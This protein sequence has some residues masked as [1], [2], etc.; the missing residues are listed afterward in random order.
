[1]RTQ[2]RFVS[3]ITGMAIAIAAALT[4]HPAAAASV[5]DDPKVQSAQAVREVVVEQETL[6]DGSTVPIV[7]PVPAQLKPNNQLLA[8][9]PPMTITVA[10]S[11]GS[12]I[13]PYTGQT[14]ETITV[15]VTNGG[16]PVV[17]ASVV[18]S[19]LN[20]VTDSNGQATIAI[21]L[22]GPTADRVTVD[23]QAA[24]FAVLDT[25]TQ[26]LLEVSMTDRNGEPIISPRPDFYVAWGERSYGQ[27]ILWTPSPGYVWFIVPAETPARVI[28]SADLFDGEYH[29]YQLYQDITLPGF[30]TSGLQ[31]IVLDGTN[32]LDLPVTVRL[33]REE[34]IA[35]VILAPQDSY[36]YTLFNHALHVSLDSFSR[37]H[38]TPGTYQVGYQ[39][40]PTNP[41]GKEAVL[42][43]TVTF[44]EETQ[45]LHPWL[46]SEGLASLRTTFVETP[47]DAIEGTFSLVY[48][49][50]LFPISDRH[51]YLEPG[52]YELRNVSLEIDSWWY[53]YI[54]LDPSRGAL[55]LEAGKAHDLYY[56]VQPRPGSSLSQGTAGGRVSAPITLWNSAGDALL[57][58]SSFDPAAP[59]IGEAWIYDE[60]DEEIG[61]TTVDTFGF[62][63]TAPETPADQVYTYDGAYN[64]GP[65]GTSIEFGGTMLVG[66]PAYAV[67]E[68]ESV[69]QDLPTDLTV[70]V[71]GGT[72]GSIV[73]IGRTGRS[74]A[75]DQNG[76]AHFQRITL[77]EPVPI[78]VNGLAKGMVQTYRTRE[79]VVV[80]VDG[81]D[82]TKPRSPFTV[83]VNLHGATD[84]YGA[85]VDLTLD[86]SQILV[87]GATEGNLHTTP[88]K[89]VIEPAI[90][91]EGDQ[92][93]Y[94]VSLLG[95]TPGREG[96]ATLLT[97]T[98]QLVG[99]STSVDLANGLEVTLVDSNGHP[100][101]VILRSKQMAVGTK[102]TGRVTSAGR[103]VP[104]GW[105]SL[106]D[107]TTSTHVAK[108]ETD[109]Q[110]N[111]SLI[112]PYNGLFQVV[113]G[114]QAY[115][116]T[117]GAV[118]VDDTTPGTIILDLSALYG[119]WNGDGYISTTDLATLMDLYADASMAFSS[120]DLVYDGRFDLYDLYYAAKN[121]E[122][123][124]T[125]L[126]K[127]EGQ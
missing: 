119:D 79:P 14:V 61:Y 5:I 36:S 114:G 67:A 16:A 53:G 42:V 52:S 56:P 20:A 33:D 18:Y 81:P 27:E 58:A 23:G 123:S 107:Q 64:L 96:D 66:Q 51:V 39:V 82:S 63:W 6:P 40:H 122:S 55:T 44:A 4:G 91:Q 34:V 125:R 106:V 21:R 111:F 8:E 43:E 99:D 73:T 12:N 13:I 105:V 11:N 22:Y 110:G 28:G 85:Q 102:I 47:T 31:K 26:A 94:L 104:H 90:S 2:R 115:D 19:G 103:G 126:Q 65:I 54:I 92:L 112:A 69:Y 118:T 15:T 62:A 109:S 41:G 49:K 30:A 70:T 84:V 98:L 38:V 120:A 97:M 77:S 1:M 89:W 88:N 116:E 87:T 57:L 35:D 45:G 7:R 100:I 71:L 76:R 59:P 74:Q 10:G 117:P 3:L 124:T 24:W 108:T 25:T 17:G 46:R 75:L 113:F 72:P 83:A 78:Y 80:N 86:P 60:T 127:E 121:I 95:D 37:L 32:A 68:P 93:Q 29:V 50:L 48:G 101:P 9:A